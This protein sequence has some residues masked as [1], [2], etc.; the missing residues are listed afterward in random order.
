MSA[1][2][3]PPA[4]AQ[5]RKTFLALMWSLSYPGRIHT[6]PE[7]VSSNPM[8]FVAIGE[9]LLDLET[10]FFTPDEALKQQLLLTTAIPE[11]AN[12]AEYHFYPEWTDQTSSFIRDA[13]VG[14]MLYPDQSA[15]LIMD[16]RIGE[17]PLYWLEGPGIQAKTSVQSSLPEVFW[18]IREQSLRYPLGWDVFLVDGCRV[19]GLPRTT[20]VHLQG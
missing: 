3:L 12:R 2:I 16:A 8:N 17:G 13:S 1:P 7:T 11:T 15:T 20:V 10:T 18:A 5:A 9:S 4:E 14:T 19:M 6:I